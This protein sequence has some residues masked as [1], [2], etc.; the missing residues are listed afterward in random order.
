MIVLL[1]S[2]YICT[3]TATKDIVV[4]IEKDNNKSDPSCRKCKY[5]ISLYR[6]YDLI[7]H[8]EVLYRYTIHLFE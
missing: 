5:V 4:D 2:Y 6:Y 7:T 3:A 8:V 1:K